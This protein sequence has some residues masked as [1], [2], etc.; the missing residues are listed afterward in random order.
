MEDLHRVF[1]GFFPFISLDFFKLANTLDPGGK[2]MGKNKKK[3]KQ[4][5]AYLCDLYNSAYWVRVFEW[6]NEL[7]SVSHYSP[8]G[9]VACFLLQFLVIWA[10]WWL[11]C[12]ML[13]YYTEWKLPQPPPKKKK[14]L[15]MRGYV[16]RVPR[17]PFQNR[18]S[19]FI[20]ACLPY[21]LRGSGWG[22]TQCGREQ[23]PF[24][25]MLRYRKY[26][27]LVYY[28]KINSDA[29]SFHL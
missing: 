26:L 1:N 13:P 27:K 10:C 29:F 12:F 20:W 23:Q 7:W 5:H 14:I 11:F 15:K 16:E 19:V 6:L 18:V 4:S 28:L 8:S 3:W 24:F 17:D 2:H 25:R 9:A 21:G 22:V